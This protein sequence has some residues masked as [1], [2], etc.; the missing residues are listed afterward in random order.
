MCYNFAGFR[1]TTILFPELIKHMTPQ[2]SSHPPGLPWHLV[3][4]PDGSLPRRRITP[5]GL[6]GLRRSRRFRAARPKNNAGAS[7]QK[8]MKATAGRV[9]VR[10]P[11]TRHLQFHQYI[12]P[13]SVFYLTF[14]VPVNPTLTP[15]G[16]YPCLCKIH[17]K[18]VLPRYRGGFRGSSNKI[19]DKMFI[20]DSVLVSS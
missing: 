16:P 20:K 2:T 17:Q 13:F 3:L 18:I 19:V 14:S 1:I 7:T 4:S 12:F 5:L 11:V 9:Y 10:F 6:G 15:D 8:Q